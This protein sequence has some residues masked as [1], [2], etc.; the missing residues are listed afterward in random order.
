[1]SLEHFAQTFVSEL[2]DIRN[3]LGE[4]ADRVF[5]TE[6]VQQLMLNE[7]H[8]AAQAASLP[9][10]GPPAEL[11]VSRIVRPHLFHVPEVSGLLIPIAKAQGNRIEGTWLLCLQWADGRRES[12]DLADYLDASNGQRIWFSHKPPAPLPTT[13][14]RWSR[15][16][17]ARWRD[18]YTPK[19][20]ALFK[21][22]I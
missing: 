17:R 15:Q 14:S 2:A 1:M 9:P 6:D 18:G 5:T 12:L 21:R 7:A 16:S 11:D 8:R 19:L 20:D 3:G 4:S 13:A 22:I 10:S